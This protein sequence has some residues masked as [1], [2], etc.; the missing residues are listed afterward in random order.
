MNSFAGSLLPEWMRGYNRSWLKGD[1][2]A[3]LTVGVM[4]IPQGMAYA[5]LAGVPPVYGLYAALI[6]IILYAFLGTSRQLAVGPVAM[7]SILV[8]AGVGE[9]AEPGTSRYL[10]LV[11]LTTLGAGVVQLLMGALRMGFLVNFLAH[12]VLA[13]FTSAAAIIIAVSQLQ[14]L[15]G[16]QTAGGGHALQPILD[17]VLY[18]H[19]ANPATAILGIGS[20]I[21]IFVLKRWKKTF[22]A[23][24]FV[25]ILGSLLTFSL[26]LSS[27]GVRIVGEI[28]QGL[29]GFQSPAVSM[30]DFGSL[31]PIILVISLIGYMESMAMAKTLANKKGYKINANKELIALGAANIGGAF[32]QSIPVTGG[33]SRTAVNDQTGAMSGLAS[34]I[35]ASTITLTLLFFTPL[36]YYLPNAVL[37]A[38]IITAVISLFDHKSIIR[39]WKTD[40]RDL[41]MMIITL[42]ATLILGIEEGIATGV[43][44]SL[45]MLVYKSTLPHSTELG[46][47]GDTGTY[48]NTTRYPEARTFENLLIYRYD[49]PLYFINATNFEEKLGQ[50][51]QEKGDKIEYVILDA[52]S[53]SSID[54]TGIHTLEEILTRLHLRNVRLLIAGA[55]GPLRDKLAINGLA[56]HIGRENFFFDV[57][58]AVQSISGKGHAIGKSYSPMQTNISGR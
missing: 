1:I 54:S 17:T 39:L 6:P 34:L 16:M 10:E 55:I 19:L 23:A 28:P 48:R 58:D 29:P 12:P 5:V 50:L 38:V 4:L 26:D 11:I 44:I 32:F 9:L 47:L 35:S 46:Q 43:I 20:V 18:T 22:P 15:F 52:S 7:L 51:I 25:V 14:N 36:F 24:L 27:V 42:L 31:L 57:H 56:D 49:A 13:G 40:K 33:L 3:G 53:M 21:L 45:G 30:T 8:F 37:A 41:T 2:N